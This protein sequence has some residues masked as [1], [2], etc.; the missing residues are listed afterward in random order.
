MSSDHQDKQLD[1]S[2]LLPIEGHTFEGVFSFADF[3]EGYRQIGL[4]GSC[5]YR[6]IEILRTV[7]DK[8]L[9]IYLGI[10][11]NVGTCGLREAVAFLARHNHVAAIVATAGAIEED[12]MKTMGD[13]KLGEYR[14]NNGI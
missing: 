5:L 12:V 3:I 1:L 2:H 10:T 7:R 13:F 9:P 14:N 8:N 11:S 6:S 4:Q